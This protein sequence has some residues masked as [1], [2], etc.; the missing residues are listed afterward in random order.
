MLTCASRAVGFGSFGA[1]FGALRTGAGGVVRHRGPH[2]RCAPPPPQTHIHTHI[3]TRTHHVRDRAQDLLDLPYLGLVL[4]EDG[5]VEVR[6]L[7][8]A[9]RR[10][11]FD[12][13]F[14]SS[15]SIDRLFVFACACVCAQG[16]GDSAVTGGVHVCIMRAEAK[17]RVCACLSEGSGG[18]AHARRA[19]H[20]VVRG[21]SR[22]ECGTAGGVPAPPITNACVRPSR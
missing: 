10:V 22:V 15:E 9:G 20:Q 11:W 14:R 17:T 4:Q 2:A 8:G 13:E 12:F 16:G 19:G 3:H 18:Q 6:D 1:A 5:R 7:R 21:V